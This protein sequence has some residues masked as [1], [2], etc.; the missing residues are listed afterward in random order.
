MITRVLLADDHALFRDGIASLMSTWGIEVIGQAG[1]GLEALEKAR[2]LHPDVV[3]MD[4]KMPRCN[5]L[6]ATRLIKAEMPGT[7][8]VM[9]TMSDDE[10]DLFEA[11]KAGAQGYLL[12]NL[13]GEEFAK[14]IEGV[15]RGEAAMSPT[16]ASKILAEFSRQSS[17]APAPTPSPSP[18]EE[19]SER[20]RQVLRLI[21][22]GFTNKGISH[23]LVVSEHTV[24]YHIKNILAKLHLRNRA[25]AAAYAVQQGL[26]DDSPSA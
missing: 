12:K 5:G 23:E 8:I 26:A 4:V 11:I 25:Q 20:E 16:L 19:L 17:R 21:A 3:L 7:K 10:Q 1:D 22:Q 15:S 18:R 6:E 24:N 14:M 13:K 2:A 9:L